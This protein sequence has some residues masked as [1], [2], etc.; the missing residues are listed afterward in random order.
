[1]H[2][3]SA[4]SELAPR[5]RSA[6]SPRAPGT[7]ITDR[8]TVTPRGRLRDRPQPRLRLVAPYLLRLPLPGAPVVLKVRETWPRTS[9]VYCHPSDDWPGADTLDVVERVPE[10]LCRRRG[11]AIDLVLDRHREN[12]SQ[13]VFTKARGREVVFWQSARTRKQA[14][15]NVSVPTA[16][17]S[18]RV[19]EIVVD[20]QEKYPW[21]FADQQ[22]TTTRRTLPVGDDA[23]ECGR[24]AG[25]G[26]RAQE[27]RRPRGHAHVGQAHVPPGR[28]GSSVPPSPSTSSTTARQPLS[29]PSRPSPNSPDGSRRRPRCG[30]GRCRPGWRSPTAADSDPR[31]GGPTTS[32][33]TDRRHGWPPSPGAGERPVIRPTS[34]RHAAPSHDAGHPTRDQR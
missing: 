17:A 2:R 7:P 25:H 23:V 15:P 14:R 30:R 12:R 1:M 18:G 6:R 8:T 9:K 10:R 28:T 22:A 19:L 27:P 21:T 16:R 5:P 32:P 26:G 20:R 34:D 33:T 13:F 29:P 11:A 3:P 31:S 4:P 24:L